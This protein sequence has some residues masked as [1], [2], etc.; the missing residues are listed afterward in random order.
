[1][2]LLRDHSYSSTTVKHSGQ[3]FLCLVALLALLVKLLVEL[4]DLFAQH[5][6]KDLTAVLS[7]LVLFENRRVYLTDLLAKR[8]FVSIAALLPCF[9]LLG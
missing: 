6:N 2:F 9:L 1:M 5:V 3:H 8:A 4:T 7:L